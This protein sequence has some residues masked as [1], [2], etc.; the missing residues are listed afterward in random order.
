MRQK[1]FFPSI[2]FFLLMV[3]FL[4]CDKPEDEAPMVDKDPR[5]EPYVYYF[6]R[7]GRTNVANTGQIVRNLIVQDFEILVKGLTEPGAAP[8]AFED[9]YKYYE[10][11][12]QTIDGPTLTECDLPLVFETLRAISSIRDLKQRVNGPNAQQVHEDMA[13]WCQTIAD[14]SEDPAKLG[15]Y[16]VYIEESTGYDLVQMF[17]L[18]GLGAAMF[19]HGNYVY[20]RFVEY[21]YNDSLVWYPGSNGINY[22]SMEHHWDEAFGYYG[23]AH[24]FHDFS[25]EELVA[26]ESGGNYKDNL[27]I[28]GK[29]DFKTE[30]NFHFARMAAQRDLDSKTGTDFS[31]AVFDAFYEGR[32]AIVAKEYETMLASKPIILDNWEKIIA[33]TAIHHINGVMAELDLLSGNAEYSPKMFYHHWAAMYK[34]TEMLRYN[35]GN[36]FLQ[37]QEVLDTY[38]R[39]AEVLFPRALVDDTSLIEGYVPKLLEVR[40][41]M[42]DVY[43]F[44]E[45]DVLAW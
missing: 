10:N 8:I 43:N 11:D 31:R 34:F 1:L 13:H 35:Y 24:N 26:F 15:T 22:T 17:K 20:F 6:E 29:I 28:D 42:Q 9:L 32:V 12:A 40:Q 30:Y 16:E 18:T 23:A 14:N 4:G 41:L 44:D 38:Y 33:S 7:D 37:Y 36:R 27:I 45:Q 25:D 39:T 2:L 21:D 3:I 5:Y 19:E